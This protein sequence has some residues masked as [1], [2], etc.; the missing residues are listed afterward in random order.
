MHINKYWAF[1]LFYALISAWLFGIIFLIKKRRIDLSLGKKVGIACLA[2]LL[3][4]VLSKL[5]ISL[6]VTCSVFS[7]AY[8]GA[9]IFVKGLYHRS[10][11]F[12]KGVDIALFA[13]LFV[14]ALTFFMVS[15]DVIR[16]YGPN[17]TMDFIVD[18]IFRVG[19]AFLAI[20]LFFRGR[21][22]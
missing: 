9:R 21:R 1:I 17:S 4:L 18:S 10:F 19:F 20:F 15:D 2:S 16:R 3:L 12:L 11:S 7:F 22:D 8:F 6:V 14:G 5:S 13:T